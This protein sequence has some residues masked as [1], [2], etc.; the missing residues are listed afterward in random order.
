MGSGTLYVAELADVILGDQEKRGRWWFV[1]E[2][3]VQ[4]MNATLMKPKGLSASTDAGTPPFA[5][6]S[7]KERYCGKVLAATKVV[8]HEFTLYRQTEYL[9]S[10]LAPSLL[11]TRPCAILD[12]C[13][14]IFP[15]TT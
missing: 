9:N 7:R 8:V 15:A 2:V 13:K 10:T 14:K 12:T 4:S 1:G 11:V 6:S 3:L 5:K